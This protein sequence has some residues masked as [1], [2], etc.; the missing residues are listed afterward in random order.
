MVSISEDRQVVV[1][2]CPETNN[3]FARRKKD[4]TW[5]F[6]DEAVPTA[7][8]LMDDFGPV[9]YRR[10]AER[11]AAEAAAALKAKRRKS[12]R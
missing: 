8:A 12:R 4:G 9:R 11:L 7:D 6:G 5:I 3:D 2:P 1:W 10:T